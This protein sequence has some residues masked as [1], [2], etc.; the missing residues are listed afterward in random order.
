[1][2]VVMIGKDGG[3]TLQYPDY[4]TVI[5]LDS[6]EFPVSCLYV[7]LWKKKSRGI[8]LHIQNDIFK[9]ERRRFLQFKRLLA[10]LSAV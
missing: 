2:F 5:Q 8:R 6:I 3:V 4:G 10:R 7:I 9:H 1:M